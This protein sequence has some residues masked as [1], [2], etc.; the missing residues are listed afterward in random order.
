MIV[1]RASFPETFK[2]VN[3]QSRGTVQVL[4]GV[5]VS[6]IVAYFLAD[7]LRTKR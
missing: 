3:S 4:L 6:L 2:E 1:Y 7:F 5:S